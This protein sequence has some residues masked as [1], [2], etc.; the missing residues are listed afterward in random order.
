MHTAGIGESAL[1]E[2]LQEALADTRPIEVAFLPELGMVDVR[3]TLA[4]HPR[5]EADRLLDA[6][7]GDLDRAQ[8]E[9][10]G[11]YPTRPVR[12]IAGPKRRREEGPAAG[13]AAVQRDLRDFQKR[14]ALADVV[15]V[16]VATTE[17]LPEA[18]PEWESIP[19][20]NDSRR[21]GL[22]S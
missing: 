21:N 4:G 2:R 6:L 19:S 10:R 16:N 1:A 12:P 7:A 11:G 17:P 18:R 20:A 15:V 3:L 9:V 8:A 5:A 14:N 13:F 22:T